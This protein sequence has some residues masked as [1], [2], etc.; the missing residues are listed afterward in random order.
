[1]DSNG[2]LDTYNLQL[3]IFSNEVRQR[4]NMPELHSYL[5]LCTTVSLAKLST[6]TKKDED[7][8]ITE[9]LAAKIKNKN[10]KRTSVR[11]PASSGEWAHSTPV[12]FFLKNDVVH[13]AKA[14]EADRH[15]QFFM[16]QILKYED[17][18]DDVRRSAGR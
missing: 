1:M 14:T 4:C 10:L 2:Q 11:K 12:N 18:I 13:V 5:K 15:G 3:K 9:L 7:T 17:I 16:G 6:L 8:L